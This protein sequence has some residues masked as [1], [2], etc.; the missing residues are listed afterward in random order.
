MNEIQKN[1]EHFKVFNSL[2]YVSITFFHLFLFEEKKGQLIQNYLCALDHKM[3]I[4]K[5]C[6]SALKVPNIS[7]FF[8]LVECRNKDKI[9]L[10]T[11]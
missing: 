8:V 5:D 2:K 1:S 4:R 11:S 6:L 3:S 9:N 7:N 10:D